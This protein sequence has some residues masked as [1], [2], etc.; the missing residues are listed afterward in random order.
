MQP[1]HSIGSKEGVIWFSSWISPS[2]PRMPGWSY[3]TQPSSGTWFPAPEWKRN[4]SL[5]SSTLRIPYWPVIS[6]YALCW[7][8]V[9]KWRG[10]RLK[11]GLAPMAVP[12]PSP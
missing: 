2:T 10:R 9:L 3:T 6:L 7:L 8:A 1:Y 12:V 11:K 5:H 4:E